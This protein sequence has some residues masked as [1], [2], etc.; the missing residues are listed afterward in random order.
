MSDL[1][2][3]KITTYPGTY[4]EYMLAATQAREQQS[5]DM[6]RPRKKSPS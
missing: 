4:D 6:P 3:G 1:D 2:Y 5:S